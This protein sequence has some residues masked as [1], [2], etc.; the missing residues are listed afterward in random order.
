[1]EITPGTYQGQP[2]D[3]GI[4]E[5][6]NGNPQAFVTFMIPQIEKKITWFGGFTSE[7]AIEITGAALIRCGFR[8]TDLSTLVEGV[9]VLDSNKT[10]ELVIEKEEWN[11]K[12][13]TKVKWVNEVGGGLKD[14]LDRA[15]AAQKMA[16][17]NI[18]GTM[19]KL[20]QEMGVTGRA[21]KP[22]EQNHS[23]VTQQQG[24]NANP[25]F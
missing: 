21:T 14:K 12:V 19:I 15:G 7:K 2:V 5:T 8:G 11:G 13:Y 23:Q 16:G 18:S 22:V 10:L 9:S 6:K 4:S 24:F 25:P 1:M 3:C 17:Y 20:Q